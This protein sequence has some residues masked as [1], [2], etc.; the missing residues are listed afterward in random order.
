MFAYL[1]VGTA[2]M[3][4]YFSLFK[5]WYCTDSDRTAQ[6]N[7]PNTASFSSSFWN[8]TYILYNCKSLCSNRIIIVTSQSLLVC[9]WCTTEE[10]N[11]LE[12]KI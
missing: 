3:V 8:V 2:Q 7:L 10:R 6:E 5:N 11:I 12:I 1:K 9:G 4:T